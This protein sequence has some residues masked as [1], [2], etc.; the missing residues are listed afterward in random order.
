MKKHILYYTLVYLFALSTNAQL[1][2][3]FLARLSSGVAIPSTNFFTENFEG[4]G[5]DNSNANGWSE[6]DTG[7]DKDFTGPGPVQGSQSLI[8]SNT[9][10][11]CILSASFSAKTTVY[12]KLRFRVNAQDNSPDILTLAVGGTNQFKASVQAD[13]RFFRVKNLGETLDSVSAVSLA[14]DYYMWGQFGVGNGGNGISKIWANTVNDKL[15]SPITVSITNGDCIA[16]VNTI[17]IRAGIAGIVV[18]DNIQ[19]SVTEIL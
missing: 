13:T 10:N 1:R 2:P 5:Y 7:A 8:I 3:S 15:S 16:A 12:F 14:T 11:S 6:S 19:L 4:T 9:P 18:W 17:T